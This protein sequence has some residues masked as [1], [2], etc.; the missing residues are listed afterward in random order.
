M[1]QLNLET[2]TLAEDDCPV[3][4]KNTAELTIKIIRKDGTVEEISGIPVT[5]QNEELKNG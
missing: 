3:G 2:R 5:F 4:S 1:T